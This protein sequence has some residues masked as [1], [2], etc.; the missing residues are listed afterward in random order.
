[1][2]QFCIKKDKPRASSFR[3]SPSEYIQIIKGQD[4]ST[5]QIAALL[6][7]F[8]GKLSDTSA[9]FSG[10]NRLVHMLLMRDGGTP[11]AVVASTERAS[12]DQRARS[13]LTSCTGHSAVS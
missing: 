11:A 6:I 2:S 9:E 4:A 1:M 7:L 3:K 13:G 12:V 10:T 5:K 8:V